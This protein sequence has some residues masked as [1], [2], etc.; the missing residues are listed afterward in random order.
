MSFF[1]KD[2][3]RS[4]LGFW[5]WFEKGKVEVGIKLYKNDENISVSVVE[6]KPLVFFK[7]YIIFLFIE[8]KR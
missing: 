6:G 8:K 4:Q 1:K 5:T 7:A 3:V 2:E